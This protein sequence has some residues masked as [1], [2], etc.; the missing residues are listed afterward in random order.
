[1]EVLNKAIAPILCHLSEEIY[2]YS[3]IKTEPSIFLT[4][5]IE[6]KRE[7]SLFKYASLYQILFKIKDSV[8]KLIEKEREEKKVKSSFECCIVFDTD[9]CLE[10]QDVMTDIPKEEIE[11]IL[12]VSEVKFETITNPMFVDPKSFLKISITRPD[13]LKCQRCWRYHSTEEYTFCQ[14]CKNVLFKSLKLQ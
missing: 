5:W 2:Q 11:E 3:P 6:T 13:K 14:R 4:G 9:E 7:W 8:F 1:L 12:M 10:I